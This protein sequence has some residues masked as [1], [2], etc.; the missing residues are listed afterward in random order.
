METAE[1]GEIRFRQVVGRA[2]IGAV[3]LAVVH[4]A[5]RVLGREPVVGV[6][7]VG[8][9]HGT[10]GDVGRRQF[11][12]VGLVLILDDEGQRLFGPGAW[13]RIKTRTSAASW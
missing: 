13:R 1:A 3:R 4:P 11:A 2:V 7:F 8:T 6:R 5:D 10:L 9:D 12:E